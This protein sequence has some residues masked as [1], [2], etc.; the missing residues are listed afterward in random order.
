MLGRFCVFCGE[1]PKGK[2]REHIIPLWLLE[3]TGNPARPAVLGFNWRRPE[4]GLRRFGF[5][6]FTFPACEV[7]NGEFSDLEG[8]A[9]Q[10]VTAMLTDEPVGVAGIESL[11]DWLDKVRVGLWLGLLYLNGNLHNIRPMYHISQRMAACDRLVFVYRDPEQAKGVSWS[12]ADSPIFHLMP[13]CMSVV[14]NKLHLF[15]ASS[16]FLFGPRMGF[17][18]QVMGAMVPQGSGEYLTSLEKGTKRIDLPLVHYPIWP[19][20]TQLYQPF[21]PRLMGGVQSD[22]RRMYDTEHVRSCLQN[23]DS[24]RGKVFLLNGDTLDEYPALPSLNWQPPLTQVQRTLRR[25]LPVQAMA[26]LEAIFTATTPSLDE[27]DHERRAHV[28]H[29]REGCLGLHRTMVEGQR[30]HDRRRDASGYL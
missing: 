13:S 18:S 12:G 15:N 19:G 10:V 5:S 22:F 6:S 4:S 17:P 20:G 28:Q 7:C 26:W 1:K 3:M 21:I 25:E 9:K 14:I 2:N 16:N 27:L 8:R 29:V 11:L 24:G 30:E 23:F